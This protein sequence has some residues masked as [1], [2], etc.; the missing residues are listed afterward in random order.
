MK[1][2]GKMSQDG[3]IPGN[4]SQ[5][6][7]EGPFHLGGQPGRSQ[8]TCSQQALEVYLRLGSAGQS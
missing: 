1:T 7:P 5:R 6:G 8:G 4:G 3:R 2:Y